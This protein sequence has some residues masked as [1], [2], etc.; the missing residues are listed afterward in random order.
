MRIHTIGNSH[1]QLP[2]HNIKG[3]T[4]HVC[5]GKLCYSIGR[6]GIDI[7]KFGINNGDLLIF[8]FGEVDARWQIGK[9][10]KD[11]N[12]YKLMIDEI[13][14]KYFLAIKNATSIFKNLKICIYNV[15]PPVYKEI[16]KHHPSYPRGGDCSGTDEERKTYALYFNY[17]FKEKCDEYNY[18]FFDIYYYLTDKDGFLNYEISDKAHHLM[19]EL[20]IIVFFKN[21]FNILLKRGEKISK[22][23]ITYF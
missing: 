23:N 19:K 16:Y 13:V 20:P 12:D 2:W 15:L 3:I 4:M 6:D 7:S 9:R 17:K 14:D 21:K 1:A 10:V 11:K 22:N 8:C 5:S 18:I